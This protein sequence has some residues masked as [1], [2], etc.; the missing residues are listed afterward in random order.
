MPNRSVARYQ[1][2]QGHPQRK[3][4]SSDGGP[5]RTASYWTNDERAIEHLLTEKN[6]LETIFGSASPARALQVA[7]RVKRAK[8]RHD[9]L[10][11][12]ALRTP[13]ACRDLTDRPGKERN[14]HHLTPRLR[15]GQPFYGESSH[16][17]ILIKVVRHDALH[18]EFGRRT[19]EEIIRLLT[20]CAEVE[21][22]FLADRVAGSARRTPCR[23]MCRRRARRILQN[24]R[25]DLDPGIFP[26]SFFCRTEMIH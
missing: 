23:K 10:S 20:L 17:K 14:Y 21:R 7:L 11:S 4:R 8:G 24:P 22:Q 12:E 16:N 2:R 26:G 15:E 9:A 18:A 6:K 13:A 1:N 19:L 25:R 5:R 3:D